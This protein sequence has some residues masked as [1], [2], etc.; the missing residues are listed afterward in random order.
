MEECT[1]IYRFICIVTGKSYV[2]SA[3]KCLAREKSHIRDLTNG[4]HHNNYFQNAWN[5]HGKDAF[6]FEILEV[7]KES[8]LRAKEQ[9]WIFFLKSHK[10]KF[11]FNI[12]YPVRQRVASGRMSARHKAYWGKLTKEE[13]FARA[14]AMQASLERLRNTEEYKGNL[15]TK[16]ITRWANPKFRKKLKKISDTQWSDPQYRDKAV[17]RRSRNANRQWASEEHHQAMSKKRADRW[18]NAEYYK[19]RVEGTKAL[20]QTE[21]YREKVTSKI[22]TSCNDPEYKRKLSERVTAYWAAKRAQQNQGNPQ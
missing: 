4:E 10:S 19:E 9:H 5:K 18:K 16:A 14:A 7:C 3:I 22:K 11:G 12:A 15:S 17:R 1:G 8:E 20:W 2:G 6:T 13:K 21:E